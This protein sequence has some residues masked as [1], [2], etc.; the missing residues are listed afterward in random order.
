MTEK[1]MEYFRKIDKRRFW[2]MLVGNLFLGLGVAIFKLS[3]MGNDPCT[4]MVMAVSEKIGIP[5]AN[6]NVVVN[7]LIFLIEL[8][9]GREL[10]GIGTVLNACLLGYVATFFYWLFTLPFGAPQSLL[11]RLLLVCIGICISSFGVAMYQGAD[12]G[13]SPWDSMSL[14]MTKYWPKIPYFWHRMSN[15]ALATVLCLVCG[16]IVGLGTAVSAF[17]LG[18][19][20]HF[21]NEHFVKKLLGTEEAK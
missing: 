19:I 11:I 20:I 5:Y 21:C 7:L 6:F 2:V 1:I 18:P 12:M 13:V 16:G 17:C 3:G 9:F 15:D 4:G 8:K 14:I 10:I